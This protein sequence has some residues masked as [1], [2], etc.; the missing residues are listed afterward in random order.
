MRTVLEGR[1]EKRVE[2]KDS[3]ILYN[4]AKFRCWGHL[5]RQLRFHDLK[6]L[7]HVNVVIPYRLSEAFFKN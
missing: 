7:G 5:G 4:A 1:E 3:G 6:I 2:S